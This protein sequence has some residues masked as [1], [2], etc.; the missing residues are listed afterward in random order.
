MISYQKGKYEEAIK[1]TK[2]A[3]LNN[4][5][6]SD[7]H[8]N[9]GEAYRALGNHELSVVYFKQAISLNSNN[10]NAYNNLALSLSSLG[11]FEEAST[12]FEKAIELKP[13]D[14]EIYLNLGNTLCQDNREISAID[15]YTKAINL[16]PDFIEA[17]ENLILILKK[18]NRYDEAK[19]L[20][21]KATGIEKNNP[22]L[23]YQLGLCLYE[24]NLVDDAIKKLKKSLELK[25]NNPVANNTL[26]IIHNDLGELEKASLYYEKAIENNPNFAD[27]LYNLV[28]L[29][30]KQEYISK[31]NACLDKKNLTDDDLIAYHFALGIIFEKNKSYDIAFKHYNK[32]NSLKKKLINYDFKETSSY[33]NRLINIYTKDYFLDLPPETGSKSNIPVFIVGMPRSGTTLIEQIVSSHPKVCGAG[34]LET[35]RILEHKIKSNAEQD[36]GYPECMESYSASLLK[37]YSQQYLNEIKKYSEEN[38]C[39][40]DKMPSNFLRIGFIKT[41]FPNA[42]IIHCMRD[43]LDTC[44]SIYL[45]YFVRGNEFSFDLKDIGKYYKDYVRLMKHWLDIFGSDILEIQYENLI[46]EQEK[47]SRQLIQYLDLEWD[48]VCLTYYKNKRRVRTASNIQIRKPL[49]KNS[50][51][52]SKNFNKHLAPLRE[53]LNN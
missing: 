30:P 13:N 40:T 25:L 21:E 53:I 9:F 2:A 48:N 41:I 29:N 10:T 49:Y 34:E 12:N 16:K 31:I 14:A 1:Y 38:V 18:L 37:D 51:N 8:N 7:Y 50:I 35:I 4:P 36:L 15:A 42:K 3:I 11:N 32:A 27:A 17:Y 47:V 43:P 5:D 45:N 39:V 22:G 28:L 19:D 6:I 26:G 23:Y 20:L 52:R 24:L 44:I 46:E 33:I